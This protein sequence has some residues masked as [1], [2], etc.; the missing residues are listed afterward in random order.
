TMLS[1]PAEERT[2]QMRTGL[3]GTMTSPSDSRSTSSTLLHRLR[4]LND[5]AAWADFNSR[6]APRIRAWCR[7]RQIDPHETDDLTQ[8]VIL[9]ALQ[10]FRKGFVYDRS[11]NFSGWLRGV[12]QNSYSDYV[13]E[14]SRRPARAAGGSADQRLRDVAAAEFVSSLEQ[15]LA[16]EV[17][18]EAFV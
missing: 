4:D 9:G 16:G 10:T 12:W 17:L 18:E 11:R 7:E 6:Y 5:Q 15:L 2:Q 14:R 13:R 8:A 1:F 3:F